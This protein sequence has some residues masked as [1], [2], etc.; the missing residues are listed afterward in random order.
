[1]AD[2]NSPGSGADIQDVAKARLAHTRT[3]L[4]QVNAHLAPKFDLPVSANR[5]RSNRR[6]DASYPDRAA[7]RLR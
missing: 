7:E 2:S 5:T 6:G 1:V 4:A 3:R